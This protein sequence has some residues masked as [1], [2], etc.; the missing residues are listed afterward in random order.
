[1]SAVVYE[2]HKT[3]HGYPENYQPPS[4]AEQAA[5]L[6]Q[7]FPNLDVEGLE[8]YSAIYPRRLAIAELNA[9]GVSVIPKWYKLCSQ[10]PSYQAVVVLVLEALSRCYH[11]RFTNAV[12]GPVEYG[13]ILME[14]K[15]KAGACKYLNSLNVLSDTL[16]LPTQLGARWVGVSINDARKNI[17]KYEDEF[18]LGLY[19]VGILLLTH[20]NRFQ[21]DTDLKIDCAGDCYQYSK[22]HQYPY[23]PCFSYE[24]GKLT[25]GTRIQSYAN[26]AY[27][28]ATAFAMP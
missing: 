19:E 4:I 17:E 8:K 3:K 6:K 14:T 11:G 12:F 27:G 2:G 28:T 10:A 24:R 16:V 5:I 9:D 18:P 25:V 23:A 20:Q 13:S 21:N 15:E 26:P 7:F 22:D 1:M